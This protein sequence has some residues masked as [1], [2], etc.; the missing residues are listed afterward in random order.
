MHPK[1]FFW[2][3]PPRPV[4]NLSA[5][6][7][8]HS[9]ARDY[10][11]VCVCLCACVKV[12]F[13]PFDRLDPHLAPVVSKSHRRHEY[14]CHDRR[15]PVIEPHFLPAVVRLASLLCCIRASVDSGP[16]ITN[17]S[18]WRPIR[19]HV[20]DEFRS[21][22]PSNRTRPMDLQFTGLTV[23]LDKRLLLNQVSG[24]VQPGEVLAVMGPSGKFQS[25]ATPPR[26]VDLTIFSVQD[27]VRRRSSTPFR[28]GYPSRVVPSTLTVSSSTK[29][30]GAKSATSSNRTSSF[31]NWRWSK[32]WS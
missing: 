17:S 27:R 21:D 23:S 1:S 11:F 20:F 24:I 6:G 28:V 32:P 31:P 22:E 29:S 10:R 5:T 15:V 3:R 13:D 14:L 2:P 30:C 9:P 12:S 16:S 25:G 4:S 7:W 8:T 18:I 19:L 26:V